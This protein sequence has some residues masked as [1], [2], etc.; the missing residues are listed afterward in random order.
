MMPPLSTSAGLVL[1]MGK[2]IFAGRQFLYPYVVPEPASLSLL[3]LGL[4][5]FAYRR[6]RGQRS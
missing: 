2:G 6:F 1:A 5:G 4:A 3:G